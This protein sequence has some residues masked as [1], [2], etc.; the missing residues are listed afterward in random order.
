MNKYQSHKMLP[1]F[2]TVLIHVY[3]NKGPNFWD[4]PLRQIL[5][6]DPSAA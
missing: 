5:G 2:I 3:K 4:A 1:E 6:D